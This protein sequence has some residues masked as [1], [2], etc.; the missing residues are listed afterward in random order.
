MIFFLNDFKVWS[1]HDFLLPQYVLQVDLT[2]YDMKASTTSDAVG[3]D[4][5]FCSLYDGPL[6]GCKPGL[7][8]LYS[9]LYGDGSSTTGYF[10]QDFVQYN[11]ISGNFQTTPTNGTVVFGWVIVLL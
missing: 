7:Q 6:P 10:V 5:N 8:C 2:L 1:S 9:V 4:D 3:C 11:R